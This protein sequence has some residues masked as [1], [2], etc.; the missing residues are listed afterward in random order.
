MKWLRRRGC[1]CCFSSLPVT[2]S[3]LPWW[4]LANWADWQ[5]TKP[6]PEAAAAWPR[7]P[8]ATCALS[9]ALQVT[10]PAASSPSSDSAPGLLP[11]S[12]A[13]HWRGPYGTSSSMKPRPRAHSAQEPPA[14]RTTC[15]LAKAPST[16][17]QRR[18][19]GGGVPAG[20]AAAVTRRSVCTSGTGQASELRANCGVHASAHWQ[21]EPEAEAKPQRG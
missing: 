20:P 13:T 11:H 7:P 16:Q 1:Q 18:P 12:V 19:G 6:E 3:G 8:V 4:T 14:C 2:R 21:V 5:W 15:P 10:G 9:T 17:Q